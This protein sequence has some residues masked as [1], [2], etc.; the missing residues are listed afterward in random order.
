[1]K[2]NYKNGSLFEAPEDS[3]LV[4]ACNAKGVWGR[5]IAKEFK[6]R[7]PESFDEYFWLCSESKENAYPLCGDALICSK[8]NNYRVGCLITSYG[9]LADLDPPSV[10]LENTKLALHDICSQ[11][12][13]VCVKEVHSN[14]FN[15]G[16]FN[17]PWEK[18]EQVLKDVL[19]DF[20]EL[21]W[22]VWVQNEGQK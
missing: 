2:L 1:M 19:E 20:P 11:L 8:E 5:G 13:F 9:Y 21:T 18:T 12:V 16:L 4:H 22:T 14:M 17:V 3:I 10:V 6:T 15:S 7:F